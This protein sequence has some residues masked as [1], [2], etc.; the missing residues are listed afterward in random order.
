MWRCRPEEIG[1]TNCEDGPEPYDFITSNYSLSLM[2]VSPDGGV[3]FVSLDSTAD[4]GGLGAGA[5][6]P[7]GQGGVLATW[8]NGSNATVAADV[9]TPGGGQ[10]IFSSFPNGIG[11]MVLGDNNT[12]FATDG[13]NV[14]AFSVPSFQTMWSYSGT[15]GA[16]S[17][18]VATSG[19]GVTINDS[20]QGVIQLDSSGNASTPVASLQGAMP[21][22]AGLPLFV[23]QDGTTSGAWTGFT[24][25]Q[26]SGLSGLF[27]PAAASVFPEIFG[28][29]THDNQSVG[30]LTSITVN[31]QKLSTS[32]GLSVGDTGHYN[33]ADTCGPTPDAPA[34]PGGPLD[35]GIPI[36]WHWNVEVAAVVSD[37]PTKWFPP[38]QWIFDRYSGQ[39]KDS[40][41]NLHPFDQ[42]DEF[43][44]DGPPFGVWNVS[45]QTHS[46]FYTDEPGPRYYRDDPNTEEPVYQ[47]NARFNVLTAVCN[48][49]ICYPKTW[50]VQLVI[51]PGPTLDRGQ[52]SAGYGYIPLN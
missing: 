50:H 27:V 51:D 1:E 19:G 30:T 26:A 44:R 18:V 49:A 8:R 2:R 6:I 11:S 16:I 37:N 17:L 24:T 7:D 9:G 4:P 14:T 38:Q 33:L 42:N 45:P 52:S 31:F 15:P 25:G 28:G 41:G 43:R 40:Q 10:A 13:T 39:Y 34:T 32:N 20:Q 3:G 22:Q 23:A 29:G 48:R 36:G 35:C 46:I 47:A 5:V 12:A 21:F